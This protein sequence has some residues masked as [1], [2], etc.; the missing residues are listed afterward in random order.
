M[1]YFTVNFFKIFVPLSSGFLSGLLRCLSQDV[2]ISS[3][4]PDLN[5]SDQKKLRSQMWEADNITISGKDM[6]TEERI[7]TIFHQ[8]CF[9]VL[10]RKRV[11]KGEK[12]S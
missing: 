9:S 10:V 8:V 4:Q 7:T 12:G 1:V 2:L 11:K 6:L 5:E 3:L